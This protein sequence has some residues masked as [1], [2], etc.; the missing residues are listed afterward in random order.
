METQ[1]SESIGYT[2]RENKTLK[3]M[4]QESLIQI[5]LLLH[6]LEH[7]YKYLLSIE[8]NSYKEVIL[9]LEWVEAMNEELNALKRN[10]TYEVVPPLLRKKIVGCKWAY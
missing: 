9:E 6:I 7:K 5:Q 8:P 10:Q 4:G 2:P 3:R 1:N